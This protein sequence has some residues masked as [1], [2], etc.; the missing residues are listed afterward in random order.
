M[1]GLFVWWLW[2]ALDLLEAYQTILTP[3]IDPEQLTV[4]DVIAAW[5]S[6]CLVLTGGRDTSGAALLVWVWSIASTIATS[7]HL[8]LNARGATIRLLFFSPLHFLN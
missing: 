7:T 8:M 5:K 1:G 4:H 6:G 3:V 2:Q